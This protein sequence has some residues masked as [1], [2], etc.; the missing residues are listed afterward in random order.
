MQILRKSMANLWQAKYQCIDYNKISGACSW[1]RSV[2]I[3]VLA[4]MKLTTITEISAK[5]FI[6]INKSLWF[7]GILLETM[8]FYRIVF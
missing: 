2:K 5:I 7:S 1:G 3:I 4:S 8:F 6:S